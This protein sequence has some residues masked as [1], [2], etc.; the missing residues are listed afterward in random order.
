[1]KILVTGFDP[2]GGESINPSWEAVKALP[3]TIENMEII[4]L[5]LPT[6]FVN[7]EKV[8]LAAMAEHAPDAVIC[9]GQAAG[10]KAVSFE[11]LAINLRDASIADNAGY[12]PTDEAVKA[13]EREAYFVTA[14]VKAMAEAVKSAGIASELSLSAGAFVC[15]N[16]LYALLRETFGT[17]TIGGFV[18]L[19]LSP[20]QAE[21]KNPPLPFMEPEDMTRALEEAIRVLAKA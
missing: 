11:R 14:P 16:V 18:H 9:C 5:L 1:M 21:G 2:F 8:L 6:E 20:Q 19:P 4:K 12:K 13:G 3:D 10:R 17:E 7:S 15:N